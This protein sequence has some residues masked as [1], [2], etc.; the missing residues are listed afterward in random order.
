MSRELFLDGIK[1]G[2]DDC[3]LIAE[4]GHNHQGNIEIAK[5]MIATA[6]GC[7]AN[8]VKLQKRNNRKL[9][10]EE[11][12]NMPYLG[13]NSYGSTYGEHREFL[14][15][16]KNEYCELIDFA[17]E[18]GVSLFATAF[19]IPSSDFLE[20]MNIPFYKL[21]SGDITNIPLI[22]HVASFGKPI[23]LSTGGADMENVRQAVDAVL[24]TNKDLVLLQCTA[25][26]PV[27][28]YRDM[29]LRVIETYRKEFPDVVVGLSDHESGI[30][31]ALVAYTLGARV[32]EKHF[33][34]NRAWRGTDHAFSLSPTGLC[35]LIRN[36]KRA[37]EALGDGVKRR[38][39]SEEKP[40]Y[41]MSKKIVAA[42]DLPA[43]YTISRQDLAFKSP[44]DGL[45][46]DEADKLIRRRLKHPLAEDQTILLED[47]E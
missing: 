33:T 28:N 8:A 32:I 23:I 21:A 45:P 30:G 26:Y 16:G 43:G 29:N 46:P 2:G 12:Y 34:L 19:D 20:E 40:L 47:V 38:L 37:S 24:E 41:K 39:P 7:G 13:E 9:F 5:E 27:E 14:E 1:I 36:L 3:Y 18:N 6:K 35:K 44:G 10:T 11:L 15:F 4:I 17:K 22:K 31:M 42:K 25:C